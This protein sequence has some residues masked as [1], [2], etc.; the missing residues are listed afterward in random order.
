M[1]G[2]RESTPRGLRPHIV[3]AGKRN[4]G[5]S[6]LLNALVGENLAIVSPT[7]GTTTDPVRRSSELLPFGPVVFVDTAGID[8][9][10]ELG[11]ARVAKSDEAIAGSDLVLYVVE[12]LS[13]DEEDERALG[14]LAAEGR[15]V[16]PVITHGDRSPERAEALLPRITAVAG[17]PQ[18]VASTTGEGIPPLRE[19]IIGELGRQKSRQKSL[20]EDLIKPYKL[21]LLIVPIDLEAPAGR[22]ILPQVQTIREA[23]DGDAATIV[24]KEREVSWLLDQLKRPPD[25]AITDSQVVLKAA[26][27][28]PPEIPLTTFSIL[29]S[30]FKGD[31]DLFVRNASRIDTL[32]HGSRVL[33]TESCS[34]HAHCDD[35][36]RVKI[37]RWLRQY[38]GKELR[39]DHSGG[40][41]PQDISGYELLI[42]CGGCMITRSQMLARMSRAET[43]EAPVTNY[44]VAISYLHGVLDRVLEPF[45]TF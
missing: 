8:D 41:F 16:V 4:A 11:R 18:I 36:G 37:P 30:R 19:R 22:L 7:P 21:I 35:I 15:W 26:G 2:K 23:L 45:G 34:H 3:L 9:S 12:P 14:K 29:F 42:H 6:A 33:I 27:A 10:E 13:F 43:T 28:V 1:N 38:T 44:G 17:V 32:K 25:L 24:V 5:K 20:L 31:L 39:I 40:S